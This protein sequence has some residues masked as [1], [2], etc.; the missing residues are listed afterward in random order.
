LRQIA[1][2]FSISALRRF[3]Q[4]IVSIRLPVKP[5]CRSCGVRPH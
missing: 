5:F 4:R 3:F 1:A 2:H